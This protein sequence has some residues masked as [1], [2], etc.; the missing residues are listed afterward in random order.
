MSAVRR[1]LLVASALASLAAFG[2]IHGQDRQQESAQIW[3]AGTLHEDEVIG[4]TGEQWI[5]L[6]RTDS[7]YAL[8]WTTVTVTDATNGLMPSDKSVS[9]ERQSETLWL[10]RGIPSFREGPVQT[11]Y[12]GTQSIDAGYGINLNGVRGS[13][14]WS[15][16]YAKQVK[17][18]D[19]VS[20]YELTL[21]THAMPERIQILESR[22]GWDPD[23]RPFLLWAGDLDRDGRLDLVIDMQTHYNSSEPTLFL[24][25]AADSATLVKRVASFR[26]IGC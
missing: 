13:Q 21:S 24:S 17:D 4:K 7:G 12:C 23:A 2:L 22:I 25:S 9:V 3:R 26:T 5:A 10:F 1:L 15:N 8:A 14:T 11:V 19:V 18:G 16:L 20:G 6:L